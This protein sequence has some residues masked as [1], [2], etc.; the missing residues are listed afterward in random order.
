MYNALSQVHRLR[1]PRILFL[2][3]RPSARQLGCLIDLVCNCLKEWTSLPHERRSCALLGAVSHVGFN[4]ALGGC[5]LG[6]SPKIILVMLPIP[7][8][9]TKTLV[10][11]RVDEKILRADLC[12]GVEISREAFITQ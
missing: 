8:I 10:N 7:A 6:I 11:K 12:E 9:R 3:P 4:L 5:C 1:N 2:L